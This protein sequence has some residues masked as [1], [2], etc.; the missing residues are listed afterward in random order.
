MAVPVKK[1]KKGDIVFN[2]GDKSDAMY[3]IQT[4]SVRL[5]KKKGEGS[6][7]LGT[8]HKG[9]VIGEMGFL[10]GGPR[11]AS[12]EIQ[13][14]AEL[15]AINSGQM[16]DQLKNLPQ[17][18]AVL[19]KTV[20]NRLSSANN[21]I[22]QLETTT[23]AINYG[24]DSGVSA[25]Y[26]FL[27]THEILK[28]CTALLLVG[29]RNGESVNNAIKISQS[30]VL[31]YAQQIMG[32]SQSKI[33]EMLDVLE[34]V[35]LARIDRSDTEKVFIYILDMDQLEASITYMN[36]ENLKDNSKKTQLSLKAVVVM[37]YIVKHIELFPPNAE[38][39]SN[40][41]I[42]KILQLERGASGGNEPFKPDDLAELTKAGLATEL[43]IKDQATMITSVN[44]K[45]IV[46][47]FKVQKVIK[48]IQLVNERKRA[49]VFKTQTAGEAEKA[50]AKAATVE[51]AKAAATAVAK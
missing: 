9:E 49:K 37:G 35:G 48:E 29:A 21:K 19:L 46:K 43:F 6:I 51:A 1:L 33:T 17:W 2:E 16:A 7:E 24:N 32:I 27:A 4:G 12:A 15:V 28:T 36:D 13:Y 14:D 41:N 3:Y 10:D 45:D 20:V 34:H 50:A 23:T 26:E 18:I 31:R 39:F 11:S 40:V 25:G 5:Y 30:K 42:A 22:K 38:G 44:S 47:M 8:I